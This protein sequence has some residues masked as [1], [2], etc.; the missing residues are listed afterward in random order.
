MKSSRWSIGLGVATLAVAAAGAQTT[1]TTA[2]GTINNIPV[3]TGTA[4]LGS[5]TII[6][7]GG[8]IG[9]G[10]TTPLTQF[11]IMSPISQGYTVSTA[12]FGAYDAATANAVI[13]LGKVPFME[14]IGGGG[15]N[16][17]A[18]VGLVQLDIHTG[19][20]Y[21][22]PAEL[23][24]GATNAST[25]ATAGTSSG[26]VAN[27]DELG[28]ISFLGDDGAS[29]R[30]AGAFIDA[31]VDTVNGGVS[32]LHMP[33]A[34]NLATT[35]TGPIVFYTQV[36]G[37]NI[38]T[39][40]GSSYERMRLDDNGN[41]GIGT[42]APGAK[43]EVN[44]NIK[45]T[46]SSG[47]SL[48]F[49]DGTVQSTAYTG[50]TCGGDY[51]EAVDVVGQKQQYAPGDLLVLTSDGDG[52]IAKSQEPYS[53][54][55]AGIYSTKPGIVGRRQTSDSK[56]ATSEVPMAMVGIVPAKV[57]AENGPIHRGDLLVSSS[58]VGYAMKGTDPS[59]MLGAVVGKAMGTLDSGT[60]VIEVLVTLQ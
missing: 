9:I 29:V 8:N 48:T 21:Q 23:Y 49:A 22:A 36:G 3:F 17:G 6:Q 57:S 40:L 52:D 35:G 28:R 20:S 47:A 18:S 51:A 19:N 50:V 37:G 38:S 31:E 46:A 42:T 59:R 13:T 58:T 16:A 43:L 24:L 15:A 4:T 11:S 53:T 54:M 14:V 12:I 7:S 25:A 56:T 33:S 2:G 30:T 34:L 26:M 1:V 44:G 5:S 60:G 41:L 10:T 55:V 45:L 27:G 32:T 39:V